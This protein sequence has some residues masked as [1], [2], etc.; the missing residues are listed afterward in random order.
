MI[1]AYKQH[2]EVKPEMKHRSPLQKGDHPKLDTITF[3]DEEEKEIHQSLIECGQWNIS[4]GR[5]D[6]QSAMMS[7]S[8]YR[9]A[10][11]EGH[12]ER[13]LSAYL[14]IYVDFDTS[15]FVSES[16]NQT[17]LMCQQYRTMIGNI[18]SMENMK[19]ILSRI[20]PNH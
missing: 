13:E 12:L 11:R 5:F 2:F 1:E 6:I 9:T 17:I 3:L 8:R 16:M 18:V 7:M 15:S 14:D 20:Y 19:K 10:P 4:V